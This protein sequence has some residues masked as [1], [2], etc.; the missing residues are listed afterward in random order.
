MGWRSVDVFTIPM[1]EFDCLEGGQTRPVCTTMQPKA[2]Q[3][4]G[5]SCAEKKKPY[6]SSL[7]LWPVF[8]HILLRTSG[9]DSKEVAKHIDEIR[10][11]ILLI[12]LHIIFS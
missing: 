4:V 1:V 9:I 3:K 2:S 11:E 12:Y 10:L 8:D 5:S 6:R 7:I